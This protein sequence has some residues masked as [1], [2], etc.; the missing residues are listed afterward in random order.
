MHIILLTKYKF[1][2][3]FVKS[4]RKPFTEENLTFSNTPRIL[5]SSDPFSINFN[6]SITTYHSKR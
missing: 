4:Y 5:P 3:T 2:I 6:D 1:F